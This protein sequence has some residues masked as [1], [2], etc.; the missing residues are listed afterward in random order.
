MTDLPLITGALGPHPGQ[1]NQ[2]I[3]VL[4]SKVGTADLGGY[5]PTTRTVNGHALSSDVTVTAS[6][7]GLGSVENAAASTLYAPLT[8]STAKTPYSGGI[9]ATGRIVT[10]ATSSG[11]MNQTDP[12]TFFSSL[13]SSISTLETTP[14][15]TYKVPYFRTG[16]G[17]TG[18]ITFANL[19]AGYILDSIADSDTTHAPSRNA[20]FDALAVKAGTSQTFTMS[21]FIETPSDK[22]YGINCYMP[23]GGTITAVNTICASGTC[24]A[25]VSIG[26]T[27]LGG[28][29]NAVSNSRQT[30]AQASANTF[31]AGDTLKIAVSSNSACADMQWEITYTRSLA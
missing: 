7:V 2:I 12:S 26:A 9:N 15:S 11:A 29:A 25:T 20:V 3:E 4:N 13:I 24:T 21:G 22:D 5:V 27:P 23:F 6:D 10:Y 17:D 18:A 1:V 8:G 31:V 14:T 19:F 30:Q 28:T 16:L